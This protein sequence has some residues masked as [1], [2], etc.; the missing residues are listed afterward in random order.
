M[1]LQAPTVPSEPKP[2]N[3]N[4]VVDLSA[5]SIDFLTGSDVNVTS[6]VIPIVNLAF[7]FLLAKL[8]NTARI[9]DGVVSL[10][11]KPYLPPI[12]SGDFS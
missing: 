8:S 1:F 3:N 11:A 7:G 12:N 4:S 6:S 2:K 10:L 5:T 9:C